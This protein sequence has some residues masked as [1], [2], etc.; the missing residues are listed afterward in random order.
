MIDDVPPSFH[1]RA[2]KFASALGLA[3]TLFLGA[4]STAGAMPQEEASGSGVEFDLG[5][6]PEPGVT[7]AEIWQGL[8]EF[9]TAYPYRVTGGPI[10]ALAGMDLC[11]E[12]AGLG[13]E[14][15]IHL[16]PV[17]PGNGGCDAIAG[18]KA[19]VAFKRGTTMPNDWIVLGGHY[20]TVPQTIYGAYD[21]GTG[22][23]L[24][25]HLAKAMADVPTNRSIVFVWF[26]GEEEGVLASDLY[27]KELKQ[28]G[29]KISAMLGF[30]MVG[31]AWPVASPTTS[32]CLCLFHGPDDKAAF[33][34]LLKRVNYDFLGFPSGNREVRYVGTNDRNSDERS[35][36]VQGY[37]TM[38]WAGMRTASSYPAYHLPTDTLDTIISTAGGAGYFEQ[39]IYNTLLSAYYTALA[40]D[41][42]AAV[43]VASFVKDG[44]TVTFDASE[45]RDVDGPLSGYEWDFGDGTGASGVSAT[46]TYAAPGTYLVTL[47]VSDNLW[48]EDTHTTSFQ[49]TVP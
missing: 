37:P 10:E 45:S 34:P 48:S 7:G 35:F 15:S 43:P 30:D 14:A 8:Q 40:V 5:V 31:I 12:M 39:G 16:L 38:R 25:R 46:H 33:E 32:N 1:R 29:Q 3:V 11:E 23:N 26:N 19:V 17:D 2:L 9:V 47:T 20:D 21:N 22:T 49:L 4:A 36:D 6:L 42:N 18:L 28:A 41:N 27:A 24:L 13:Y 44:Q